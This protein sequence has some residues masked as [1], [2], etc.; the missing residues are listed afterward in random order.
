MRN[1]PDGAVEALFEGEPGAVD[2]VIAWCRE[3]PRRAQV[4]RV[5]V[6]D[7]EVAGLD[8]FDVR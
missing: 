1:R 8:G 2:A 6:E 5:D 4:E 3:G 7:A